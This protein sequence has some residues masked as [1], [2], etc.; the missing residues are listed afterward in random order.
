VVTRLAAAISVAALVYYFRSGGLLLYGDAVA[1]INIARRIFDSLTAGLNQ[2]G[3]V[4]LPLPHLLIAPF[5]IG[6]GLWRSGVGAAI[7]SMIAY[8][9][10]AA[11]VYRLA[12]EA[13]LQMP[14]IGPALAPFAGLIA[15]V[16]FCCN[17]NIIYLQT[18][19]MNEVPYLSL[20]IWALVWLQRFGL[21]TAAGVPAHARRALIICGVLLCAAAL[22]R[23]DGWW[24]ATLGALSAA[25][26]LAVR[27][28]LRA[29]LAALIIFL[30]LCTAAPIGWLSYNRA[31]YGNALEFAN[32]QYS[33]RAIE[34]R[35]LAAGGSR[36]PASG[37]LRLATAYYAQ[38]V[39][40]DLGESRPARAAIVAVAIAGLLLMAPRRAWL[41]ALL[42]APLPF[43]VLSIAYGSVPI[44]RPNLWPWSY[45][46]VRYGTAL[47][48]AIAVCFAIA[49]AAFSS[50]FHRRDA[51]L[52]VTTI[53]ALLVGLCYG[54]AYFQPH[55]RGHY[56]L[57]GEPDRGPLT[58]REA[59]V[60]SVSRREFDQQLARELAK[61]PPQSRLLM[62]VA[63]DVGA[64]QIAG[65]PFRRV[66]NE[67]NSRPLSSTG[68]WNDALAAPATA[69]D[70]IVAIEGDPVATAV[71]RH[72]GGLEPIA[73]VA[74]GQS[75]ARI[76]RSLLRAPH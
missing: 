53:V 74:A 47:L 21:A 57:A 60:N 40:G 10:T 67:G 64:V 73:E 66:I 17:P 5:V 63:T 55:H 6:D 52:A 70:F 34:Q 61:L 50:L 30:G 39:L 37:D 56:V 15:A 72:P 42:W 48:P 44:F 2:L 7:P 43:Y 51:R 28:Q 9:F 14:Q 22:T 20:F 68:L 33:A 3:T 35:S 76:Y 31:V 11:G 4:W 41:L 25:V 23:Y 59:V 24:L 46:N 13:A 19:A 29:S 8:I 16:V 71:A 36:N 69:A 26:M 18:T 12:R 49:V 45:Y 1:H 75:H 54:S 27:R 32:G 62:Y 65:I 58:W 38:S